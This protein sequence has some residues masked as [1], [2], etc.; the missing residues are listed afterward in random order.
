MNTF[1]RLLLGSVAGVV[2][3]SAAVAIANA[4]PLEPVASRIV[5][6]PLQSDLVA[7]TAHGAAMRDL[8]RSRP[9]DRVD[10][11]VVLR[12]RN[13]AQL[14]GLLA[15]QAVPTS[16]LHNHFLSAA[17]FRAAFAPSVQAHAATIVLLERAGFTVTQTF[18]NRTIIDVRAPAPVVERYFRTEIHRVLAG[19]A[20]HYANARPAYI[21]VELRGLVDSV[22]GFDNIEHFK[23]AYRFAPVS[24]RGLESPDAKIGKPLKGPDGAFGPLAFAQGYNFPVQHQ[25]PGKP[26][27]TT[28]DGSG[29]HAG[30]VIPADPSDQDLSVF[31]NFFKVKRTGT[32]TRVPVDG[33]PHNPSSPAQVEAALDY[34]TIAGVAPGAN[35][36]IYEP[37][38]FDNKGTLDGYNTAVS[39][40]VADTLNSSF[41]ACETS[42]IFDVQAMTHVIKQG[43]A[44]GQIFHAST[45]DGGVVSPGCNPPVRSVQAPAVIP[46]VTAIGGT[47]LN[48]DNHGNYISEI[49]WNNTSGAGGGGV[50]VVF[51]L[52]SYQ[53]PV[54]NIVTTGRNIPDVSLVGDPFTGEDVVLNGSF[55]GV[56]LGGTSLSSPLFGGCIVEVEQ[57]MGKRIA[58]LNSTLYKNF[59][60]K[61]YG[62]GKTVFAHDVIGGSQFDILK[63]GPGYDLATGIGSLDC[64]TGGTALL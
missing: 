22:V 26:N 63:P 39:A 14:D 25:I 31:L 29:R 51:P 56:G 36:V 9:T 35:I 24:L 49:Y 4:A 61:G 54:K 17:Q 47:T 10:L 21:P 27:G 11:A 7:E 8:G 33:G 55:I 23:P 34:E 60:A 45:G 53:K 58:S 16:P 6:A 5:S 2:L 50:S 52:P 28:F 19:G 62:S 48:V 3:L 30:I 40:N 18:A 12:Y 15:A 38:T 20:L 37:A 46:F 44:Q 59:V 32:T 42:G 41:G 13:E 64:F 57:V 43:S 1:D